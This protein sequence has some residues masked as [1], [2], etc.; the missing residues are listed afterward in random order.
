MSQL[1]KYFEIV[2]VVEI[3]NTSVFLSGDEFSCEKTCLQNQQVDRLMCSFH[4]N[5]CLL[6][7]YV[8]PVL[9]LLLKMSYL[10]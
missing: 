1:R 8:F 7:L 9:K 6:F 3:L 4:L 10:G 5:N 2:D